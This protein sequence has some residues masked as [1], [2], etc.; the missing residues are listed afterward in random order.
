MKN[1]KGRKKLNRKRFGKKVH[2]P[3]L[4]VQ[5]K[6]WKSNFRGKDSLVVATMPFFK[7]Y[8]T[9]LPDRLR[10]CLNFTD[11]VNFATANGAYAEVVYR[12]NGPYDP[13]Q[14]AGGNYPYGYDKLIT[15]YD[16]YLCVASSISTMAIFGVANSSNNNY[17]G[18]TCIYPSATTAGRASMA[19][20]IVLPRA[21]RADLMPYS[22]RKPNRTNGCYSK[23]DIPSLVGRPYDAL[24]GDDLLNSIVLGVP[25]VQYYWIIGDQGFDQ[26]TA[27][28]VTYRINIKYWIEFHQLGHSD[29]VDSAND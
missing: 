1:F 28:A 23:I 2:K 15:L 8:K 6:A 19:D 11:A 13:R 7:N 16:R 29:A 10:V 26:A 9:F 27:R 22:E 21:V 14:A 25:S 4:Q 24:I 18:E 20:A 12:I 3:G 17:N 5:K